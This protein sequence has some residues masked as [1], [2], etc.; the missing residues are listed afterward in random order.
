MGGSGDLGECVQAP[1]ARRF[2]PNVCSALAPPG[3]CSQATHHMECVRLSALMKLAACVTK[4]ALPIMTQ[5]APR[6][7][8][9]TTTN[10]GMSCT[11][12]EDWKIILCITQEA[13]RVSESFCVKLSTVRICSNLVPQEADSLSLPAHVVPVS[14]V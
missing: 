7:E 12:V 4:T 1:I 11:T 5:C 6:M 13:V 2:A 10:A 14:V 3:A 8:Q 9:H